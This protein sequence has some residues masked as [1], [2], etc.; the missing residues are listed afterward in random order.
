MS[1]LRQAYRA[2]LDCL[3]ARDWDRLGNYVD[4]GVTRNGNR[5]GV[6]GYRAMLE[7]DVA[8][9]PDIRFEIELLVVEGAWVASR[10]SFD[11]HPGGDFMGVAVDGRRVRFT[12]NVFYRFKGG[13]VVEVRSVVDKV[14]VEAELG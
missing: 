14:A 9:V 13:K 7:E 12:E 8:T 11:C 10:L 1:D 3:N 5:L 2:Y 4:E 6:C